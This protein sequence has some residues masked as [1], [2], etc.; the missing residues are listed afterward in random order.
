MARGD[1]SYELPIMESKYV[2]FDEGENRYRVLSRRITGW[3]YFNH[4]GKPVRVRKKEDIVFSNIG[5][6]KNGWGKSNPSHFR[7]F[8]VRDYKNKCI[9]ILELRQIGI[10]QAFDAQLRED[11]YEDPTTYDIKI[12]RKWV[13]LDTK[14]TFSVGKVSPISRDIV[15]AFSNTPINLDLLYEGGDPY[16]VSST[17]VNEFD[18]SEEMREAREE[19]WL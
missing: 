9:S 1:E 5:E 10:L 19:Y 17:E 16:A 2:K 7:S 8:V 11:W 12:L 3:L 14:Y 18:R 6:N 15:D 13:G 4:Q